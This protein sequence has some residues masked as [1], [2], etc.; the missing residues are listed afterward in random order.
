MQGWHKLKIC[1]GILSEALVLESLHMCVYVPVC[2]PRGRM[3]AGMSVC[4]R[5]C[6]WGQT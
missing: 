4:A 1:P 6:M 3:F 2:V 5:A